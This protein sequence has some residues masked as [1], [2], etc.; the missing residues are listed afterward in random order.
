MPAELHSYSFDPDGRRL[1]G[2]MSY[3][4]DWPVVYLID[5][6]SMLYI[7]E[8]CNISNRFNQ[9][10]SNEERK[11]LRRINILY[12]DQLNKSAT[13]DIEQSLIQM[14]SA[15]QKFKLQ[16]R[17]AGQSSKH[18]YYQRELYINKL[19]AIWRLLQE[20]GLAD[21]DYTTIQNLD[22]F[23]YSPYISLTEEQSEISN[24][25]LS[26]VLEW[27]VNDLRGSPQRAHNRPIHMINGSAGTGKTVLAI[28]MMFTLA[29][30]LEKGVDVAEDV[31]EFSDEALV[32]HSI[33]S[34]FK[35]FIELKAERDGVPVKDCRMD[36]ALVVPMTSIRKTLKKVF[37]SVGGGLSGSMVIGPAD[38]ARKHYD[39]LFV[40][41][42]HRLS[43]RRNITSYGAFDEVN[44]RLGF[45]DSGTQ[46]DWVLKQGTC[47]VLFYDVAQSVKGSDIPGSRFR[48]LA[49]ESTRYNLTMQMRCDGGNSYADY[50]NHIFRC[51]DIGYEAMS[52]YDFRS[53]DDVDEMVNSIKELDSE[54]GLCRNVAGYSWKWSTKGRSMDEIREKGL[55]DIHIG[56]HSYVWNMSNE[57][58]I[59]RENSI[60][61]IG[62]I[63]TTQGYDL[64]YVG[65]IFG[66]E[67]DYDERTNSITIDRDLFFDKNVK[68]GTDD[69]TL[70][71]YIIN[72]YK[73]MMMRG[74]KG[75]YVYACNPGLAKYLRQFTGKE[76]A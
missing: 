43:R 17:C 61:E 75:C 23:K 41:E 22:I 35:E 49:E 7:G 14:C 37:N 55:S 58:W 45:D 76:S 74:I 63:H 47:K 54:L 26:D 3:G 8:T 50:L 57:E 28:N 64:N 36:M 52:D 5:G 38:L 56:P 1:V 15:D 12:D 39:V 21:K 9:H 51:D 46:L 48:E 10:L 62:C 30:A 72:A 42:S 34:L 70:K 24:L 13:L 27:L 6:S 2:T 18:N 31:S 53:F 32:V 65:V 44:R 71:E 16:N 67:I 33:R 29:N 40:D 59:L 11:P 66:Y 73:V 20:K 68:N 25:V 4:R 60:N 19:P 69:V